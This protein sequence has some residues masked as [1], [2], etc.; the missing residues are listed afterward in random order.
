[1]KIKFLFKLVALMTIISVVGCSDDVG[2]GPKGKLY[3][4]DSKSWKDSG[5]LIYENFDP[6][7][8]VPYLYRVN[9]DSISLVP[10]HSSNTNDLKTYPFEKDLNK[11]ILSLEDTDKHA[12]YKPQ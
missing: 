9:A 11:L 12:V 7:Y 4:S 3:F 2:V 10:V 1:M 5:T 6:S 8:I